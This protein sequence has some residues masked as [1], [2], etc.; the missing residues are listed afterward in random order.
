VTGLCKYTYR[1]RNWKKSL[2]SELQRESD[3]ENCRVVYQQLVI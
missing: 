1:I 3:L 2:P